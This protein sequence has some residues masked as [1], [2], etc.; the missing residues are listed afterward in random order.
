M[1]LAVLIV[2]N[3]SLINAS[4]FRGHQQNV[5]FNLVISSNNAT[6]CNFTYVENKESLNLFNIQ[7]TKSGNDG[8]S[9]GTQ[10]LSVNIGM[11]SFGVYRGMLKSSFTSWLHQ[12]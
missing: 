10:E 4:D 8:G 12:T 9:S 7:M 2:G 5:D 1:F 6:A 11:S 3:I